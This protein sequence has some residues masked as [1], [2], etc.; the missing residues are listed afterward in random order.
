MILPVLLHDNIDV[1]I[2]FWPV[3]SIVY[4]IIRLP[5]FKS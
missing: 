4:F 1:I 5:I 2:D 3:L